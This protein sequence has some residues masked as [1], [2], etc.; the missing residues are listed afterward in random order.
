MERLQEKKKKALRKGGLKDSNLT[1]SDTTTK[2][3]NPY[4]LI[5]LSQ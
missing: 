2:V 3:E 5:Q 4:Q 1:N